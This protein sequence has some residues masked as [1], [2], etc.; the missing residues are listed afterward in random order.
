MWISNQYVL[1]SMAFSDRSLLLQN[2]GKPHLTGAY[3]VH[4][5]V[6]WVEILLN[7]CKMP[8][9][10]D[11]SPG[12][13][14][15]CCSWWPLLMRLSTSPVPSLLVQAEPRCPWKPFWGYQNW[16][17]SCCITSLQAVGHRV[18][19]ASA[20][21]EDGHFKDFFIDLLNRCAS[22]EECLRK[23]LRRHFC[24]FRGW[25]EQSFWCIA[26]CHCSHRKVF[27]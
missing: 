19:S 13:D 24:H 2:L 18:G 11:L 26:A 8:L 20:S 9:L 12:N 17:I 27:M 22:S 7:H 1:I 5:C 4:F 15:W 23:Y 10:N 25:Y 3:I 14:L 16:A 6:I 21:Q